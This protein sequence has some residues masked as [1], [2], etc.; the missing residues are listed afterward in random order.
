MA[1]GPQF[2]EMLGRLK[3]E[4]GFTYNPRYNRFDTEGY[5]VATRPEAERRIPVA[6]T[7][8]QH[9]ADY[10][11]EHGSVLAKAPEYMGGWRSDSH[12]VLDV[13][14]VYPA[15]PEGHTASRYQ[16]LKHD[17]EA[18]YALHTGE[19]ETN[20]FHSSSERFPEFA[21]L[22]RSGSVSRTLKQSPEVN[23]WVRS[24]MRRAGRE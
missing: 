2:N 21:A 7:T 5:A 24:P 15:T 6:E 16:A 1:L 8:P 14:K 17:Q 4:G 23:A 12:D 18:T 9:L 3:T 13:T 11:T 22:A 19:E 10:A 20:P